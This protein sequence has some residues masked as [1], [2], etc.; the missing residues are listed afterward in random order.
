M[1]KSTW[2]TNNF[3]IIPLLCSINWAAHENETSRSWRLLAKQ[4]VSNVVVV[5]KAETAQYISRVAFK[6]LMA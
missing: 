4:E 5:H 2:S 6:W 3:Q 1:I